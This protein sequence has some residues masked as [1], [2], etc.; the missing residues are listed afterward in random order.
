MLERVTRWQLMAA[1]VES[2]ARSGSGATP[3]PAWLRL[4]RNGDTFTGAWSLD[5]VAWTTVGTA[6]VPS[7]AATQ[8]V[9]VVVCSHAA[10]LGRAIFDRLE[11]R[12]SAG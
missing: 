3:S 4:S 10:R 12:T 5:G 6:K 9:G 1:A 7:A 11:V 8:D 2:V